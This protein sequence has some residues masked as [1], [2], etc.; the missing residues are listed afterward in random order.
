VEAALLPTALM[1]TNAMLIEQS[2]LHVNRVAVGNRGVSA[3]PCDLYR[4]KDGWVLVQVA[5][6]PMFT[7]WCRMVGEEQWI[8]DPGL[9]S[10]D[11]RA[12][13]GDMLNDRMQDW[14]NGKTKADV[15]KLLD[16]A[17]IPASPLLS[18]QGA[19]DDPHVK[20]MKFLQPMDFPG[21]AAPAPV[22][23]T[24]FRMS[25]TPG[26]IRGRA[27]LLGEHT[28]SVMSELGYDAGQI[29]DLRARGVI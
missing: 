13:K 7:R 23:E 11:L 15:L 22:M 21:A 20:A 27:P 1:M 5:G 17:R 8:T 10:D 25:L 6:Q 12:S 14:C 16:A 2:I 28:N 18:P 3:A 26:S 9:A 24:P 29:A 19:L 4:L